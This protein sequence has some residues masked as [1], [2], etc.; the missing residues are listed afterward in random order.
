MSAY[1]GQ[2]IPPKWNGGNLIIIRRLLKHYDIK[3]YE[4]VEL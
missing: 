3:A 2:L 4:R 1:S